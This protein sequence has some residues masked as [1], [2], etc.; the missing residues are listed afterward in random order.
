MTKTTFEPKAPLSL[1]NIL[2]Q[3]FKSYVALSSLQPLQ[4]WLD[5]LGLLRDDNVGRLGQ[6]VEGP[7]LP[8]IRARLK[9]YSLSGPIQLPPE[10]IG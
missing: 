6:C 3:F 10:L 4:R 9:Y 1:Y 2:W 5:C 8:H 7:H